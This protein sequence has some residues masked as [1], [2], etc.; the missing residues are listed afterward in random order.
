MCSTPCSSLSPGALKT[1][2]IFSVSIYLN[3]FYLLV[4]ALTGL[5][6]SRPWL[7]VAVAP[8]RPWLRWPLHC[9]NQGRHFPH[10][11]KRSFLALSV[12]MWPGF[13]NVE[14]FQNLDERPKIFTKIQIFSSKM[15]VSLVPLSCPKCTVRNREGFEETVEG[16]IIIAEA[17]L[18]STFTA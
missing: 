3:L 12:N 2:T 8:V 13:T 9:R 5:S 4:T 6:C 14:T 16:E 17:L 11:L 15:I 18:I 7:G 10:D 1:M